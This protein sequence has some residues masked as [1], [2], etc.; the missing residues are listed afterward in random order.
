MPRRSNVGR[1]PRARKTPSATA[2]ADVHAS[3]AMTPCFTWRFTSKIDVDKI[4]HF[5]SAFRK[6]VDD[7]PKDCG[8]HERPFENDSLSLI[9]DFG[10]HLKPTFKKPPRMRRIVSALGKKR[11]DARATRELVHKTR[12]Q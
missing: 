3:S 9:W 7:G 12:H 5:D 1:S 8:H 4:G 10:R 2:V 6:F 11:M